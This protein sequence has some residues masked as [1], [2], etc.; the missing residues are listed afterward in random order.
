MTTVKLIERILKIK[1]IQS[2]GHILV[3]V[4]NILIATLLERKTGIQSLWWYFGAVALSIIVCMITLTISDKRLMSH[5]N[6]RMQEENYEL[7]TMI[8]E[9][10]LVNPSHIKPVLDKIAEADGYSS[11]KTE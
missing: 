10:K 8:V 11:N 7:A 3:L 1:R 9:K 4:M 5:L 2:I 6:D